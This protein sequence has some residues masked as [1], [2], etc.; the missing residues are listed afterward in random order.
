MTT[1]ILV[2][3]SMQGN[4][5][6]AIVQTRVKSPVN[7]ATVASAFQSRSQQFLCCFSKHTC[8]LCRYSYC[9]SR[10]RLPSC[11]SIH[12]KPRWKTGKCKS[13]MNIFRRHSW[14]TAAQP[15]EHWGQGPRHPPR[16]HPGTQTPARRPTHTPPAGSPSVL[17]QGRAAAC[18]LCPGQAR[19]PG[20]APA[21]LDCALHSAVADC[22]CATNQCAVSECILAHSLCDPSILLHHVLFLTRLST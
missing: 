5:T 15:I 17:C 12:A 2:L 20:R 8:E 1:S 11:K 22:R 6:E 9:L 3:V 16:P 10:T 4:S 19:G 18:S 13:Q 7:D 14:R 21:R